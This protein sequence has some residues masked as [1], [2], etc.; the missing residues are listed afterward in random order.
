[1]IDLLTAA[2]LD[3]TTGT[4]AA[5]PSN[6]LDRECDAIY[7]ARLADLP[8]I[9]LEFQARVD[10]EF[11]HRAFCYCMEVYKR[12]NV[13]PIVLVIHTGEIDR[14]FLVEKFKTTEKWPYMLEMECSFVAERFYLL[15]KDSIMDLVDSD[16]PLP[17]LVAAA[18][19]FISR[20]PSIIGNSRW[21]DEY[22]KFMYR[23]CMKFAKQD[24]IHEA[25]RLEKLKRVCMDTYDQFEKI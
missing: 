24:G 16:E 9:I 25:T 20:S 3:S 4:Y 7:V 11:I 19:F 12:Y 8:P 18:H 10:L 23:L 5:A 14:S 13:L 6:F 21:D 2:L 22:I 1:F 17:P 15:T